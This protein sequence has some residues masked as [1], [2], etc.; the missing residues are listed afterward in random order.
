MVRRSRGVKDVAADAPAAEAD[1][2]TPHYHGH[3]ERLR[4]RFR[5]AP[6]VPPDYELV[7]L[8]LF[9]VIPRIDV[10]PKAKQ[11]IERFGGIGGL[12]AAPRAELMHAGLSD[13]AADFFKAIQE[14]TARAARAEATQRPALS[15]WNAVLD[16]LSTPETKCIGTPE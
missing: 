16:Y 11:L 1:A 7:E 6:G 10:K 9:T 15:S 3:R 4:E 8:L 2:E 14:T 13:K 5:E 12:L